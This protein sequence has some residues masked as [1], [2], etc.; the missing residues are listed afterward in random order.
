MK[1]NLEVLL[2][3][4]DTEPNE[5]QVII[6]QS[7]K[8]WNDFKYKIN[9]SYNAKI[10]GSRFSGEIFLGIR[11]KIKD[12]KKY[13]KYEYTSL[14]EYLEE[15]LPVGGASIPINQD[16]YTLLPALGYYR[17]LVRDFGWEFAEVFL[18]SVNDLAYARSERSDK[19]FEDSINTECFVRAFMRNSEPFFAYNNADMF[20]GQIPEEDFSRISRN[21]SLTFHLEGFEIEH[22][23]NLNYSNDD[24]VPRRINVLIG[25]NGL[26]KSQALNKFCRAALGYKDKE[27]K[28]EDPESNRPMINRLLAI[29]TPG[30]TANTFPAERRKTQKLY[31]RRL[32]LTR[33]SRTKG[34]GSLLVELAR[35]EDFI[36]DEYRWG[37]FIQAIAKVMPINEL[38]IPLNNDSHLQISRLRHGAEQSMLD[39]YARIKTFSEPKRGVDDSYF[40]LSSGQLTFFKFALL[41]SLY[42]ENGSFVLMDEPETHLHPN[43]VS[44]FVDMFDYILEKTGSQALIAT[45]SSYFVREIPREQVH[46]FMEEAPGYVQ[47]LQPRLRTFGADIDSISQFVFDEDV[48]NRLVERIYEKV[49]DRTF[50]QVEELLGNQ[51]SL[52]ALMSLR[53]KLEAV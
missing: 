32:N 16:V 14:T 7:P 40:P 50:A 23:L 4:K 30:E 24:I 37:I 2:S 48:E 44:Q 3:S 52:A 41:C 5:G 12:L 22:Q 33:S 15:T 17:E 42:I 25:K 34:I 31:Y 18:L 51:I 46:V 20:F 13:D 11:G 38:Y 35:S 47:I 19:W 45:H 1:K 27:I 36:G 26:G 8:N 43:L 21:L 49:K 53:R 29:G 9:C 28:L 10:R 6:F 39:N